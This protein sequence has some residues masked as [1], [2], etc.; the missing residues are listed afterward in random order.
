M[1]PPLRWV[2]NGLE[3]LDQTR[4]PD[5]TTWIRCESAE[6]VAGAIRRLAV[7]GAP[8]IGLAAAASRELARRGHIRAHGSR[9][10]PQAPAAERIESAA[11]HAQLDAL[12]GELVF[13]LDRL[14]TE[15]PGC[16]GSFRR[17]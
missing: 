5:G 9:S 1:E 14:A 2:D 6:E 16:S 12:R 17:I 4:L 10:G 11:D 3:L 15:D 8:L 7:R 13:E